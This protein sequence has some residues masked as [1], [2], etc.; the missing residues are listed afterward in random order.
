M[1]TENGTQ[2]DGNTSF[3]RAARAGNLDKVLEHLKNNID[4]NTSNAN[5]LNALHLASKDGHI[6]VVSEL[7]RRGAI[8]DSATKKGNTALHIA[9]LAGQE[10]VV[11]MLLQHGA[12]VNVQSQNGFTPL[13]MAAQENHDSVVKLLLSNGANQSLATEDGFTPLAVAMQQGHDKVVAVLLE[14]DTRGKVRLPA[15]HIAAKKDDVKAATLLLDNDHNPDVTSKSGFT[16]LHI[17]SHY[18]NQAIANL[19]IQKG[20][21]VN[22]SAKHNISPLHVAAKWGK[23][24]MVSLLLEKGANIEAK[25]RD[26][27]TPLHCAARSGHEQVVDMLLERGAPISAKTKNGLAPLHMAAQGEHVDA[28]RILLYHRAPVDEVT[29]DYLTALHVAAHCGHVRVAKLLLDRNADANARALNGF[30]PLHIACKKN[31]IKV[32]ELLLRHGA[33]ISATTE[34]GLTPLH[35]AAFMGCMNIV[36]YLLQHDASP[37]VPTVRGETPLH[38]AARANQTDIIRILLRNGAQV[39]ARAR[40]Q[41]TPLHIA[42]RLGNVDIVMLLLQHGAQVDA[43]TKDMYTALH[44]AAKEG[45]DEVAAV[46]I[47]NGAALDAAT[48]KGFTPLH[49]TAKYGHIKVAQLLL[50]K[51]ADVDAQGKNGVTPLH[52]ACHYDNQNV[53]LLLLEKGASPHAT[54]K[55][56]HTPLHIAARKNQMD[57]ATTLLEYGAQANAESKAGFTPLHLS[58]QEGHSEISNLLI[59]HKAG[60]NHPAKNGLTPMHLCAQEDNVNVAEILQRNGANIDMA[61]KAGYT[62]L[63]VAAHFGQANMVRFLLQHGAN[64]DA[65]TSIGYTPLH[66]SAQQGHCHIVKLLLEHNAN[67]NAQT[68][69]GQTPLDIA[70]KL[71]YI[72]VLD[73][74]KTIT[75]EPEGSTQMHS[76]EKYRVVA[77]E[78][79]HESFMSDSEEEGGEDNMLSDQPYR[80]LTVD[81]MKSLGDDSLPIDVTRDERVDSNRMAQSAEYGAGLQQ[82][83]PIA[84]EAISPHKVQTYNAAAGKSMV[85]GI[86]MANGLNEDDHQHVG[87]K[88]QWKSFLVSFLVDARGGAMRGCRHSGVRMI[89]PSRSTCQPT[90]VTCRYVKPQRTMHPPQLMEGE[91]LA[92]RVLELGPVST[93]FI[94]PVIMEVPHFASLRGKEREIIILRSD[95]GE[96]W[97]EHTIDNSEEIIHDVLQQCFEPEEIAQLEE[98]AGNHVCRF[99]TYDFPQYFAVVTRIRQ[100]VHAIG[101]EGGMVSSTVVPQVQAVFPQG[102][103]T[104]K[105]KVGLQAQPVDPDLTAKLLGRGVA[106]SP[107]VTVEPRRR[108]FHKAITL[109][110]PAPKAH[111][112]GMINQYSG[113]T[114]TLRLLCSITGGPSRAQW[115]DVTGSTPLTFVNDCVSFTTTVSARFWLMDCRNI[116]EATKMATE[117][118][119]EVI[120]VPFIAKF[121]VFAKKVEPFEARLRVFCM[122][123]DREDKTLEKMELYTQ[124]AKSRDVEVLEGKPQYIEM[125]GNLVPV[126]KS[127]EQL[128][129]PFKAFRENRLP[130]TVRVKDQHADI[131]GRTLFMKEPK[132]AKGE[133]PQH[134]ICILN[135][136]LP[137]AVIPD[138]V[139]AFSDKIT[140]TY[141]SSLLSFSKHQNDHYIGD[142]R[143]VD[144][145]NLLGK[146]WIQLASEINISTEEVDEIINQ[147]TDSI[148]RQAQS[149]IRLYKDKPNYD[150]H[151]LEQALKNIGRD[152]IMNKC[153]SGRLSHSRDFDETDIMK[154]SE[155]VEELV[156]QESKRI[157]QIHEREEIKYSAEEKEIEESESDEEIAK[158]TV[159]ERR[160]KIVKRLSVERQI[161]ASSQKKEITREITE[162]KRKS[163]IEDKKAIHE[164]EI[165]MQLPADNS[166]K[167]AV[168]PEQVIKMKMGKIDATEVSKSDFD[169]ELTHKFKSSSRSSEEEPDVEDTS[170]ARQISHEEVDNLKIV[171]DITSVEKPS[172]IIDSLI[173]EKPSMES[174]S[175]Q[176]TEDFLAFEKLTQ[177]PSQ[178]LP[179]TTTDITEKFVEEVKEKSDEGKIDDTIKE[180]AVEVVTETVETASKKVES[181]ISSFESS[182]P[183]KQD[184]LKGVQ[185]FITAERKTF[186]DSAKTYTKEEESKL[187]EAIVETKESIISETVSV[188]DKIKAFTETKLDDISDKITSTK[189]SFKS[190]EESKTDAIKSEKTKLKE[191][192][193]SETKSVSDA[194]KTFSET[195]VK[196]LKS[197]TAKLE[198]NV[199]QTKDS[200]ETA[201]EK[202]A[203]TIVSFVDTKTNELQTETAALQSLIM[204]TKDTKISETINILQTTK[205]FISSETKNITEAFKSKIDEVKKETEET[206]EH[207]I[208]KKDSLVSETKSV[209][210]TIKAFNEP[211]IED[212]KKEFGFSKESIVRDTKSLFDKSTEEF[213]EQLSETKET[214]ISE[215]QR[216]SETIKSFA[217]PKLEDIEKETSKAKAK[218]EFAKDSIDKQLKEQVHETKDTIITETKSVAETIKVFA[219]PKTDDIKKEAS[220]IETKLEETKMSYEKSSEELKKHV[221]D[222]KDGIITETK[223]VTETIKAFTEPKLDDFKKETA[224]LEKEI[225]STKDSIV[226]ETKSL[227]DTK[228]DE[229]KQHVDLEKESIVQQTESYYDTKSEEIKEYVS[230]KK[231]SIITETKT[232]AETIKA[233]TEPKI[234]D[235]K[236]ESSK[237][238]TKVGFAR[239]FICEET[240]TQFDKKSDKVEHLISD[241]K[242]SIVE[243]TM[244]VTETIKTFTEPK[245]EDIKKDTSKV[246]T[247]VSEMMET[248]V[249]QT[250]ESKTHDFKSGFEEMKDKLSDTEDFIITETK[251]VAETIKS[252]SEPKV[253]TSKIEE[254]FDDFIDSTKKE[255]NKVSETIKSLSESFDKSSAEPKF[256]KVKIIPSDKIEDKIA[257]FEAK[258]VTYEYHG[259]EPKLRVGLPTTTKAEDEKETIVSAPEAAPRKIT[260]TTEESTFEES[261]EKLEEMKSIVADA[262]KI[263]KDFL[264]MEQQSQL[265]LQTKVE[266]KEESRLVEETIKTT[267][268]FPPIVEKTV[269]E[270]VT[271]K[272]EGQVESKPETKTVSYDSVF[273]ETIEPSVQETILDSR[274]LTH[275]FLSMEQKSQLPCEKQTADDISELSTETSQHS[276]EKSPIIETDSEKISLEHFEKA[277]IDAR[278]ITHDFLSMEQK[279]QPFSPPKAKPL[280]ELEQTKPSSIIDEVLIK[281][282][283]I[284]TTISAGAEIPKD[285]KTSSKE[286]KIEKE[287]SKSI[288]KSEQLIDDG[289]EKAAP[290]KD[291]QEMPSSVVKTLTQDFLTFEQSAPMFTTPKTSTD[292]TKTSTDRPE[293]TLVST[294]SDITDFTHQRVIK[295]TGDFLSMEQTAHKP[296]KDSSVKTTDELMAP[297][298]IEPRKSL[299][300]AE[301]CKSVQESITKKMSEGLIEISDELKIK[302]SDIPHSQTPPPTPI[303]TK[304]EKE[305]EDV[306][307]Q[308]PTMDEDNLIDTIKT[309]HKTTESTFERVSTI[310]TIE[311]FSI[312]NI[313][314]Y[315]SSSATASTIITKELIESK[316]LPKEM[317]EIH[318]TPTSTTKIYHT[319]D[320]PS[321]TEMSESS[322]TKIPKITTTTTTIFPFTKSTQ[323][324]ENENIPSGFDK[325]IAA[326]TELTPSETAAVMSDRDYLEQI[327][328]CGDVKRK[329]QELESQGLCP[330]DISKQSDSESE[331]IDKNASVKTVVHAIEEKIIG[332]TVEAIPFA[333]RKRQGSHIEC[334]L[335]QL[336]KQILN[337]V[338]VALTQ[339]TTSE[340]P[341]DIVKLSPIEASEKEFS[342]LNAIDEVVCEKICQKKKTFEVAEEHKKLDRFGKDT[343]ET[344]IMDD[345]VKYKEIDTITGE[346]PTN[347]NETLPKVRE[348]V[349][350]FEKK[351]PTSIVEAIPFSPRR[352][353]KQPTDLN[354]A[355]VEKQILTETDLLIEKLAPTITEKKVQVPTINSPQQTTTPIEETCEVPTMP[356]QFSDLPESLDKSDKPK[357]PLDSKSSPI[358]PTTGEDFE[359]KLE[360]KKPT[361]IDSMPSIASQ[362]S[363]LPESLDK[364]DKPKSLLDSESS[365]IKS[366]TGEDHEEEIYLKKPTII[367]SKPSEFSDFKPTT[368]EDFEKKHEIKKPT[369]IDSKTSIAPQYSDLPESLDKSEKPKSLLD[370]ESP[371]IKST[372]GEDPEDEIDIKKPTTIDSKPSMPPQF[373]E[374]PE[375][376]DKS[377]KPKSPID[378]KTS[379]V[380][381]T[382]KDSDDL[383]E[384]LKP[385]PEEVA[386]LGK[387]EKPKS[388]PY[389]DEE[390]GDE[391]ESDN[392]IKYSDRKSLNDVESSDVIIS[393]STTTKPVENY[394]LVYSTSPVDIYRPSSNTSK[395]PQKPYSGDVSVDDLEKTL[396]SLSPKHLKD[397]SIETSVEVHKDF[398]AT[399]IS[400]KDN[401]P[402]SS[403]TLSNT[404]DN[405]FESVKFSNTDKTNSRAVAYFVD[406]DEGDISKPHHSRPNIHKKQN[407]DKKLKTS[408]PKLDMKSS[409]KPREVPITSN[410]TYSKRTSI[411]ETSP[412]IQKST[413]QTSSREKKTTQRIS[414]RNNMESSVTILKPRKD[415]KKI[416]VK[417]YERIISDK[418]KISALNNQIRLERTL[419][420]QT[421]QSFSE[422]VE[423]TSRSTTPRPRIRTDITRVPQQQTLRTF[424]PPPNRPKPDYSS[425]TSTYA[426]TRKT[427]K[428]AKSVVR[429][430]TDHSPSSRSSTPN[431]DSQRRRLRTPTVPIGEHHYMQPTIA[432]SRR[433]GNLKSADS[434]LSLDEKFSK[435]P[436]PQVTA[437]TNKNTFQSK[438]T[439]P[440]SG[441]RKMQTNKINSNSRESLKSSETKTKISI[442]R[443]K[444]TTDTKQ[445]S[446]TK[447]IRNLYT[448]DNSLKSTIDK[449]NSLTKSAII[450]QVS[451]VRYNRQVSKEK[452]VDKKKIV[453][454][455]TAK[456]ED[457]KLSSEDTNRL[458]DRDVSATNQKQITNASSKVPIR[459]KTNRVTDDKVNKLELKAKV[460]QKQST[461]KRNITKKIDTPKDKLVQSK[462][463]DLKVQKKLKNTL[464][465][466]AGST[467]K[468]S[469]TMSH[470]SRKSTSTSATTTT[471][472]NSQSTNKIEKELLN[473]KLAERKSF[474][475]TVTSSGTNRISTVKLHREPIATTI[476]STVV[477]T[478]D[479]DSENNTRSVRSNDSTKSSSS[480]GSR[481]VITSE[482]FTKT[483]GPDKPFEVIYRQPEVDYMSIMRPQSV[484]QRCVNEYDVSFIDTTDSS[485]S[486]SVALPTFTSDQDRLCAASPGS[487]K[488][489][490]SPFALIEE[491]IRKQQASG[492]ALDPTLQRQFE[493]VGMIGS[494][495]ESPMTSSI[496]N[497][498]DLHKQVTAESHSSNSYQHHHTSSSSNSEDNSD[499]YSNDMDYNQNFG[500][501]VTDVEDFDSYADIERPRSRR[502]SKNS[503]AIKKGLPDTQGDVTDV[504]DYNDSDLGEE[505]DKSVIYPE[506]KVSLQEFLQHDIQEQIS[507]SNGLKEMV[508]HKSGNFLQAQ[509]LNTLSDYLTDY[510]DYNT[511]SEIE[512][513]CEK[514]VC[515][516]LNETFVEQGD[517]DDSFDGDDDQQPIPQAVVM[518]T[519]DE[520][521]CVTDCEDMFCDDMSETG[522][523]DNE[524]PHSVD[525][526]AIPLPQREVVMLQ[527]DKF[528]DTITS[529]MPMDKEYHFGMYAA[530]KDECV[531][532]TEEFSC[533]DDLNS[534]VTGVEIPSCSPSPSPNNVLVESD[535]T[536]ANEV[537]KT[538]QSKRLEIISNAESVTDVEEIYM[539]GTNSRKKKSKTRTQSKGKSKYL[540]T[541]KTTTREDG[542]GTD[543]EDM[544]LSESGLFVGAFKY[545]KKSEANRQ[546]NQSHSEKVTDVEDMTADDVSDAEL[547]PIDTNATNFKDYESSSKNIVVTLETCG[548]ATCA[549][550][551][552][553]KTVN[554]VFREN[555]QNTHQNQQHTDVE[556]VQ[557]T[558]DAEELLNNSE[559]TVDCVCNELSEML[560]ESCT[561]VHEKCSNSFNIDAEK[562][563]IKGILK[564]EKEIEK[565]M[566]DDDGDEKDRD[567]HVEDDEDDED[568][569]DDYEHE[570]DKSVID[571]DSIMVKSLS[572]N[573]ENVRREATVLV[574]N[575]L[576]ESIQFVNEQQDRDHIETYNAVVDNNARAEYN[577]ESEN[578]AITCDDVDGLDV[579]KSPTIESMSGKSFDDNLSF[580][581]EHI[582]TVAGPSATTTTVTTYSVQQTQEQIQMLPQDGDEIFGTKFTTTQT[583]VAQVDDILEDRS[584]I[585]TRRVEHKF[586]KISSNVQ[587]V[588]IEA[589]KFDEQFECVVPD[590]EISHLQGDFSKI[591]WDDSQSPT[592]NTLGD[593][594]QSTPDNDIQEIAAETKSTDITPV[595]PSAITTTLSQQS[596]DNADLGAP[597][598]DVPKPKPRSVRISTP[599]ED[600]EEEK[601]SSQMPYEVEEQEVSFDLSD[602]VDNSVVPVPKPRSQMKTSDSF[603]N[604]DTLNQQQHHQPSQSDSISLRSFDYTEETSR[605]DDPSVSVSIS[606]KS[607]QLDYPLTT[608]NT[609]TTTT[610]EDPAT[611]SIDP[612]SELSIDDGNVETERKTSFYIGESS[613]NIITKT[614]PTKLS[615]SEGAADEPLTAVM[616]REPIEATDISL[617]KEFSVDSDEENDVFKEYVTIKPTEPEA[618]TRIRRQSSET[619][620][621]LLEEDALTKETIESTTVV[622][623]MTTTTTTAGA[624][625]EDGTLRKTST[626]Q[627]FTT[628]TITSTTSTSS[629]PLE[630]IHS[631]GEDDSVRE[632]SESMDIEIE[633]PIDLDLPLEKSEWETTEKEI[634]P[635][636]KGKILHSPQQP[637][638]SD[639]T[640]EALTEE[641]VA[642]TLEEVQ[643]SLDAAKN[644]LKSVL[645]DG[646]SIKESP[647]EFEFRSFS[648]TIASGSSEG[649]KISDMGIKT[650]KIIEETVEL[651]EDE[652]ISSFIGVPENIQ[653]KHS[654]ETENVITSTV[655]ESLNRE[656]A[657]LHYAQ[658]IF[659]E[660]KPETSLG[661]VSTGTAESQDSHTSSDDHIV[662]E[663]RAS[664]G[665]I[666]SETAED[667]SSMEDYYQEKLAKA[668]IV[669]EAKEKKEEVITSTTA[670]V[671][672]F[673]EISSELTMKPFED[674]VHRIKTESADNAQ[675]RWSVP[676]IDQS[677]S[678]E[679]YYKSFEKSESRPLSSDIENLMTQAN[680]SE[681]QTAADVSSVYRETTEFVS[682]VSTFESS[683]GKTISSHE[684]MRSLDSQS[685]TSANLGSIDVSE[686]S[687]TLVASST[688]EAEELQRLRDLADEE[689]SDDS[690]DL[691]IMDYTVS[692]SKIQQQSQM[693]RSQEMI[694]KPKSDDVSRKTEGE[695]DDQ[696]KCIQTVQIEEYAKPKEVEKT[697]GLTYPIEDTKTDDFKDTDD[698]LLYH[699]DIR[700]SIDDTKYA[701]SLDE[702]SILSVSMSS[703]SNIDTVVE[704]FEDIVGSVGASSLA[705]IEGFAASSLPEETTFVMEMD[706][707][708]GDFS[709]QNSTATTPPGETPTKRG[710]KRSE[711]TSVSG[712]D[713]KNTP[714]K[715][716][717]AP[718][719][720]GKES[721]SESDTDPYETEYARQFRSPSDRKS[722]KK[723]QAAAEMDHSFETEKRPFTPSQLVAEVIV[724]DSLTEELEAEECLLE[725]R[726]PS[727]NMLNYSNIPDITV[728]EDIQ[729]KS[730]ILEEDTF[731]EK[732]LYKV[733]TQEELHKATDDRPLHEEKEMVIDLKEENFQK[734]V[735]EQY[736]QKL[737]E[738][739]K[740]EI[741]DS[742][743]DYNKAPD[744]PDSFEMV[745]Q[746]DISD[747]FVIIEEVA[748]EANEDDLGGKSIRIAPTKYES[749]HDEEVE[750][751][752]I[753]SAPADPKLGSQIFRDDLNFE[754]EESPP[755]G[756]SG[757]AGSEVQDE[758]DSGPDMAANNK[759]WVEMQLTDNQLRYPYDLTGGVLEDIKEEDGEFEVGS[760]R[761][762]SFKDSFSSTPEYDVMAARRYYAARGEHDDISMSSLQEFESL[763]QAISLENR[764]RT[765]QGSTD[766]S[767]GS[768]QRRYILRNSASGPAQGDD[769]SISSLKEFEGLENACIEAHLIEIKAK[770]EAAMLSRSDESNKSNGS[771][772]DQILDPTKVVVSKVIRTVTHT[773]VLQSGQQPPD[774]ETLL[775]QKLQECERAQSSIQITEISRTKADSDKG[776][777]DSLE[778]NRSV[779]MVTSSVDDSFDISKDGTTKSDIDSLE[780][781]KRQPTREESIESIEME[782][783]DDV[784]SK[785][786]VTLGDGL[787]TTTTTTTTSTDADG[788]EH[789]TVT[790]R[791]ITKAT[792]TGGGASSTSLDASAPEMM[793]KDFSAESLN[794]MSALDQTTT[795]S[796]GT[797]ATYQTSAGNSQM[798]GSI[799][800]CAS[801]TLME[802]SAMSM[803][804]LTMSSSYWSHEEET[805]KEGTDVKTKDTLNKEDHPPH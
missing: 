776:S 375:S 400:I 796:A 355:D 434:E 361:S 215:T 658:N 126:T 788:H 29:V 294:T 467:P 765:H 167:S 241:S 798:S 747:E 14:S 133:P 203:D 59:E 598:G 101:P 671:D 380:K 697:W 673:G 727:Q 127:G 506:L 639:L 422:N 192:I 149:M 12:S 369:S 21:D 58:C 335:P 679:S 338:D 293:D 216:V 681:Y 512:N 653:D 648:Q 368:G 198:Q 381:H 577:S 608:T 704:N 323:K 792:L 191:E 789:T 630:V 761:I 787:T 202:T 135:I 407:Y 674:V 492:F 183:E 229:F 8:V 117:L 195:E 667:F 142:I 392:I 494:E 2:G 479:N 55:N 96:T 771:D 82:Q 677:S 715:D 575:V 371:P 612:P 696:E 278:K 722:K 107:I 212:V 445:K 246:E 76:D 501:A 666:S 503:V 536:V 607:Q 601:M 317:L 549:K 535:V 769:I 461:V 13:Y 181:I 569:D 81:E 408:K 365:P 795:S 707:G 125:A 177:L 566:K 766:S 567:D 593:I 426:Y 753:K 514:S 357:S 790:T 712:D 92:S 505:D 521:G 109:S 762:S 347:D 462:S 287:D 573:V 20:A 453:S 136:V 793:T 243:E 794:Q 362:Y 342:N 250:M 466:Q 157:Q 496:V 748:K 350:V 734:L 615:V 669:T 471:S 482:V 163:L 410:K 388:H 387:S 480:S 265:P 84:E 131:V 781:D 95:N 285:T 9:S 564:Y 23:T 737:A 672:T 770:E 68:T 373:S 60:V 263:T 223:S 226:K 680:S 56:G 115:E 493:A 511:E 488:P 363:D 253:T 523:S 562:L 705:G 282:T 602:D 427:Q 406:L 330:T 46:L 663:E 659:E 645:K 533:A 583:S 34:S 276:V 370:S 654:Q 299:T 267:I 18:G 43:T 708:S 281:A 751:I 606:M 785:F 184:T 145:S 568:E 111:S 160:D 483:F 701:S 431:D 433:Y 268:T 507:T 447:R 652:D 332:S 326:T 700:R 685:E 174:G 530:V 555:C 409:V 239:D 394:S 314:P 138:S 378:S 414:Q 309:L 548:S 108:K 463:I 465:N 449:S 272:V 33:S 527:E 490:R 227:F 124:V 118:Y 682:A 524:S 315:A 694:F 245:I 778:M 580:T 230:D 178:I 327:M 545:V 94:G 162:I 774:I 473:S 322:R 106:V 542:G 676:E 320:T 591:S 782:Q 553:R 710:H 277:D 484:E 417:D 79:M 93:K 419:S 800:S 627:S 443:M 590:D 801:S 423:S 623:T 185:D 97:R 208:D 175:K 137:E 346:M 186:L 17:A 310:S 678:S 304:I 429:K 32:V 193:L 657:M 341:I 513:E 716:T 725:E 384:Y 642:K 113:N 71:G 401:E 692:E 486:D 105:I 343:N 516:D 153:K 515:V 415:V 425:I 386:S 110:M 560:N 35:V 665:F 89:I 220:K 616:C 526:N 611:E 307:Q 251:T 418:T 731:E 805:V 802:D 7:L 67:A 662:K 695:E 211:K 100:E 609:T 517:D 244:S 292:E 791:I 783:M 70:R 273:K 270:T 283:D 472:K 286:D 626:E 587:D 74:L 352:R 485:L 398:D 206:K 73:S 745:D 31:R 509:N 197:E 518:A 767:N 27:L 742:D 360:L 224:N 537:F 777:I 740:A 477:I 592:T 255:S 121:V 728:T 22:F 159:A 772:R 661:F 489:T 129:L 428:T 411:S 4:I 757:G 450:E 170:S 62:P 261:L 547:P 597:Q 228:T 643:E 441:T 269:T 755:T 1:V 28:A 413:T 551:N 683:S 614:T 541:P 308:K 139:T 640:K 586:Q 42:S 297:I 714:D 718:Q 403:P 45:Q 732:T 799:T 114:P 122:T 773:E 312:Q 543:I 3:L 242:D 80:Y 634:P 140:P 210:E 736:K 625:A 15:L 83:Q 154:N 41:Q 337:E 214:V 78:A 235:I 324:V 525:L 150:I 531:T 558:S 404:V 529:V 182:K 522:A 328:K 5:G 275:D 252:F 25:T 232:V 11:K 237:I 146:D 372:T 468:S 733:K 359:N 356:S 10:E 699:G 504:E 166:V 234:D 650:E 231:D 581:D 207:A 331:S 190:F 396:T 446:T 390:S 189:D 305:E 629:A 66:Q 570:H 430:Q 688:E 51:E 686:L 491:T 120:H 519:R 222:M 173:G 128:Q 225:T 395:L 556:D 561:T 618:G 594:G 738:L 458:K 221:F 336:E 711:S 156:R 319:K 204:D 217:E 656:A 572:S 24:N 735:Q 112:Q 104:K 187:D 574:D 405:V 487:P 37:D 340:P 26:G 641:M 744:S 454:K 164:S 151:S 644:E 691:E 440:Q 296:Q 64:V 780:V 266:M 416:V 38:L 99:V 550:L 344:D 470:S 582:A 784:M 358:K 420:P 603:K 752:I 763:E 702:G 764:N 47:E 498:N 719:G 123:D 538:Q 438:Q 528:G 754:F 721:E 116:S 49:L 364:S 389:S 759:R 353:E 576:E 399:Q 804:G 635:T 520:G 179:T 288:L 743:Y 690:L 617:M 624:V 302:E 464:N 439:K 316:K 675:N 610:S 539:A 636:G 65:A 660:K 213:K 497:D 301:F 585:R 291:A 668:D 451:N 756:S 171:K 393:T 620:N 456:K 161:P 172:K 103:L 540:E 258:K 194:I 318:E 631:T 584:T 249:T 86:Y 720:E 578:Y 85:D 236:K 510:E 98:Q 169:K 595:P 448:K 155:S 571:T 345:I 144:L 412:K 377:N 349:E 726:R 256:E 366:S 16:P 613:R 457:S 158:R 437:I 205:D 379:P 749:K 589:A 651:M 39:D 559:P 605:T 279:Q 544:D 596:H 637:I 219:E 664:L 306:I 48:K 254:K 132:V 148:A 455:S 730:P 188:K 69:S 706:E 709:P 693:K 54:A 557:F 143:I 130:F 385:K 495:S 321:F 36:I 300:D 633:R 436:V 619:R 508:E 53:A 44:I 424:S 52:V 703:T 298:P 63:H 402:I 599:T 274:K 500:G 91:A 499:S 435:S 339:L 289:I 600:V 803:S 689:D 196:E 698:I 452:A 579:I 199:L 90:R 333:V 646:K 134:P 119:K 741:G 240:K 334:D 649:E 713:I 77:P 797:T 30:T 259:L 621:D 57:I 141:R 588:D 459:T 546:S 775:K 6:H 238:E 552:S 376:L 264:S 87:R 50:Q 729:P 532:D 102:A 421:N 723:K 152:D 180:T 779:D 367:D 758:S 565:Y 168:V 40:E 247:K 632:I 354:T 303:E 233:F 88:L 329:I 604:L 684:S 469:P 72:S 313:K 351:F 563:H 502:S 200:I 209:A 534:Q 746:P 201:T 442:E 75:D 218:V 554:N 284:M 61:T 478:D 391:M 260:T 739:Q 348:V 768:F 382:S 647:S 724:E 460:D 638:L 687:E 717:S 628:T 176:L 397:I 760:S 19:L 622:N 655:I 786:G 295:M 481:K 383:P 311:H 476:V 280:D 262:R 444:S 271:K 474:T 257:D 147:N 325:K 670:G 248:I 374:L 750:K 475:T 290:I 165:F 432:H